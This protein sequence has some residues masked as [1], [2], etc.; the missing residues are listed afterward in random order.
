MERESV[1][2]AKF[3]ALIRLVHFVVSLA[4]IDRVFAQVADDILRR[5]FNDSCKQRLLLSY[6]HKTRVSEL[7]ENL[8][9]W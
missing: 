8:Q 3:N 4:E 9:G 6:Q 2:G 1:F 5:D 7:N